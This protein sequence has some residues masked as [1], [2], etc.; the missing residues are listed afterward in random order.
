ML[1]HFLMLA[2][3]TGQG[4]A[5]ATAPSQQGG[6]PAFLQLVPILLLFVVFYLFLIRPQQ[7]QKKE[8]QKMLTEIRTGD[9]V[10][11]SGGI[12]GVIANIKDKTYTLRLAEG[13]MEINKDAVVRVTEKGS[14]SEG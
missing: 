10:L 1:D 14:G 13:K 6:P 9:R 8:Q 3:A 7:K 2:Q 4:A 5:P 12:H 11:T